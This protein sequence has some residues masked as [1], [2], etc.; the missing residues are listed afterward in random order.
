MEENTSRKLHF[1]LEVLIVAVIFY[2]AAMLLGWITKS[3]MVSLI[4]LGTWTMTVV[5]LLRGIL[6][7]F[8]GN[9]ICFK[10]IEKRDIHWGMLLL[11]CAGYKCVALFPSAV[12]T[13]FIARFGEIALIAYMKI[14]IYLSAVCSAVVTT[15]L[16]RL[17]CVPKVEV[18]VNDPSA[19]FDLAAHVLLIL[20]GCGIWYQIWIYR[21][22]RYLNCLPDEEYRHPGAKLLL[23]MFVPF[24][25]IYWTYKSA[26]RID[27]LAA[28]VG[29]T[30]DLSVICLILAILFPVIPPI[31]MQNKINKIQE[32]IS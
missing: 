28:S 3:Y 31:L 6:G 30:S 4:H 5:S 9:L 10:V 32:A 1:I 16:V 22:T 20:F 12:I 18:S 15:L 23:C 17:L 11:I 25:H 26:Q 19:K 14:A 2:V 24:Y 8:L 29:V 21:V 27:K 7:L 13:S